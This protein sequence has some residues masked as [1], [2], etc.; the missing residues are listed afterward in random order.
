MLDGEAIPAIRGHDNLVIK[1]S[2][3]CSSQRVADSSAGQFLRFR[4]ALGHEHL[5]GLEV[6][7]VGLLAQIEHALQR[8]IRRVE[9]LL[10]Q[11]GRDEERVA[12]IREAGEAGAVIEQQFARL[13]VDAE[14]IAKGVVVFGF[15][16]SRKRD[17]LDALLLAPIDR[18]DAFAQEGRDLM[19]LLAARQRLLRWH[20][21]FLDLLQHRLPQLE[22]L[23]D[24][25]RRAEVR[26]IDIAFL[27]VGIVAVQAVFLQQGA[28]VLGEARDSK[29]EKDRKDTAHRNRERGRIRGLSVHVVGRGIRRGRSRLASQT[30]G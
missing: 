11:R 2:L 3:T 1:R 12:V 19:T 22:L 15:R 8:V 6:L 4:A 9:E 14:E 27:F 21:F 18:V 29:D 13:E 10:R 16:Q 30:C 26:E 20:F 7:R 17:V 24:I 23:H 25:L 28:D 5:F